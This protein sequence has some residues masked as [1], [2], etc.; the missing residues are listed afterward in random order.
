MHLVAEMYPPKNTRRKIN[1]LL[2][3]YSF[4]QV[5]HVSTAAAKFHVWVGNSF[6][7]NIKK[8]VTFLAKSMPYF[9]YLEK[10]DP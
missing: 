6:I 9:R 4:E 5:K 1:T 2:T 10:S 3:E 8:N 7:Y